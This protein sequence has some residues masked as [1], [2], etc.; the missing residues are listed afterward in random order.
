MRYKVDHDY[1]IHTELSLCCRKPEQN[2]ERILQYAK[3]NGFSSVC[4]TDHYWDSAVGGASG[5]YAPQN[6][7]HIARVKP[8]PYDR[9]VRFM[10]GCETDMDKFFNVGI[11]PSRFDDFD[12]I[13]VPTTHLHMTGFTISGADAEDNRARAAL[14]VARLE[15]LLNMPLPY[16]KVGLAHPACRLINRA[17]REDYL[18][19]LS[20]IPSGEMERLFT[21]AASLGLGIELNR[22]DMSFADSEADDVLR[23]FRIAKSCG[24]KFYLGSDAHSPAAFANARE[25]FER[26]VTL[27][28]LCESDKFHIQNS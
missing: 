24:C 8:L 27:L 15:A 3:E 4:V 21:R 6:F 11:P 23:P 10:F 16:G 17:S 12:F 13:I 19:A 22:S 2:K 7:E 20:L 1:H 28:D 5:W 18:A 14:W 9:D 25:I 26:A